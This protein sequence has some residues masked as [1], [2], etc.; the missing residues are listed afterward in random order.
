MADVEKTASGGST[1]SEMLK[2]TAPLFGMPTVDAVVKDLARLAES[3]NPSYEYG[4]TLTNGAGDFDQML[5]TLAEAMVNPNTATIPPFD[6]AMPEQAAFGWMLG[7]YKAHGPF[8]TGQYASTRVFLL[9]APWWQVKA[10]YLVL[11]TPMQ[12]SLIHI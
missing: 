12:L 3:L 10:P 11:N 4:H 9:W 7:G 1:L 8:G 6:Y 5:T 2:N